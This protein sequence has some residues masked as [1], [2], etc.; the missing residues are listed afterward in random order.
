[1]EVLFPL[2]G[3]SLQRENNKTYMEKNITLTTCK[4]VQPNIFTIVI[5]K[6]KMISTMLRKYYSSVLGEEVSVSY[7]HRLNNAQVAFLC[8]VLPADMPLPL[9]AVFCLWFLYAVRRCRR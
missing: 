1:M 3:V 4:L 2:V 8:A 6:F 9:R 7:M 5:N